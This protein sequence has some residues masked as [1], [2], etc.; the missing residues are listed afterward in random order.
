V[1]NHAKDRPGDVARLRTLHDE[2]A[3]DAAQK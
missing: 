2:W 1:T 3:K